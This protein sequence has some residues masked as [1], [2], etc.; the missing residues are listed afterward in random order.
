M[1]RS[2]YFVLII[3]IIVVPKCVSL[4]HQNEDETIANEG[5]DDNELDTQNTVNF[6]G[7]NLF[8]TDGPT[9]TCF[10]P[11]DVAML[12]YRM[13]FEVHIHIHKDKHIKIQTLL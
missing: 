8:R 10:S 13:Q 9:R 5:N 3:I 11:E 2:I 4:K 1:K 6:V 7:T 12:Q